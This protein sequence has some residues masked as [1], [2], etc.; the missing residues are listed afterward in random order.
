MTEIPVV[1]LEEEDISEDDGATISLIIT[2]N[3]RAKTVDPAILNPLPTNLSIIAQREEKKVEVPKKIDKN[4]FSEGFNKLC[5]QYRETKKQ[6]DGTQKSVADIIK[7]RKNLSMQNTVETENIPPA[8]NLQSKKVS[9]EIKKRDAKI[10][11]KDKISD[12]TESDS[13][14]NL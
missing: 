11:Q 1:P 4:G 13:L 14:Y 2:K 10:T 9:S 6:D 5:P 12:N 3:E 7:F 8:I